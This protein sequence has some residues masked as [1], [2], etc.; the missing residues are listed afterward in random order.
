MDG[1]V[2]RREESPRW[3]RGVQWPAV[4][5]GFA[6]AAVDAIYLNYIR[7]KDA[8]DPGEMLLIAAQIGGA[9]V[10]ALVGALPLP[11]ALRVPLL[12]VAATL[13][14]AWAVLGMFSIGLPLF[15]AGALTAYAA[16]A[17]A[18]GRH[19]TPAVLGVFVGVSVGAIALVAVWLP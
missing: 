5:A 11:R 2:L 15:L 9:A 8:H 16:V 12:A 10:L 13:L 6:A 1:S 14:L 7:T 18:T 3:A 4:V 19:A 17:A